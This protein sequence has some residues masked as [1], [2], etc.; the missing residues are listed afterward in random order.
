VANRQSPTPVLV[1]LSGSQRGA[2]LEL[3]R[4]V[5]RIG[6]AANMDLRLPADT[7]PLPGAHHATLT[8]RGASYEMQAQ[9]GHD[10][11]VNGELVDRLVLASGDVLELGGDGAVLRYRLYP[12]GTRPQRTITEVFSDCVECASRE[13]DTRMGQ[14]SLMARQLPGELLTQTSTRFRASLAILAVLVV[15]LGFTTW[16]L[17]QRTAELEIRIAELT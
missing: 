6:V 12:A 7:E 13:A 4:D 1:Y 10:V 9:P 11:W 3:A 15:G 17:A 14:L 2:A 5:I 16:F 8:R